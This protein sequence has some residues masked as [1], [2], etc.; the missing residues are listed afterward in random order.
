MGHAMPI[1]Q[2]GYL[3]K[4]ANTNRSNPNLVYAGVD[5]GRL[6]L[7]FEAMDS[8]IMAAKEVG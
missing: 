6:P 2:P 1:P 8:G 3:F 5:N 4:D 7:L